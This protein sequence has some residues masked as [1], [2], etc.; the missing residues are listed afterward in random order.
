M[1]T[2]NWIFW[3][4]TTL[5]GYI[6][7]F[8]LA[9]CIACGL[10][11]AA[12]LAE[13]YSSIARRVLNYSLGTVFLVHFLLLFSG[14]P[15]LPLFT[16]T[17]CNLVYLTLLP[18]FPYVEPLSLPSVSSLLA[19]LGTHYTWFSYFHNTY[20]PIL[21]VTGFFLVMIWGVPL[22]FFVSLSLPSDGLPVGIG[23]E[24]V[25][26]KKGGGNVFKGAVETAQEW[27]G[28]RGET[29]SKRMGMGK[30]N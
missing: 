6:A 23:G 24:R 22:M 4:I 25:G 9:I 21:Q 29:K 16:S 7:M 27:W 11:C 14:V 26:Q 18:S 10:Y 30:Y 3:M 28:R 19:V 5:F 13:E 20:T 12:E 15:F 2:P 1:G 17:L 8:V